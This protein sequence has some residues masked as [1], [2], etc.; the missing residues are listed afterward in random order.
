MVSCLG[1]V[2]FR[3]WISRFP[4]FNISRFPNFRVYGFSNISVYGF[5]DVNTHE[6]Q[7]LFVYMPMMEVNEPSVNPKFPT[8]ELRTSANR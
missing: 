8:S 5:P 4:D 1:L 7:F 6:V 3:F 2:V